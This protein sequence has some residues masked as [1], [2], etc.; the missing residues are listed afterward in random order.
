MDTAAHRGSLTGRGRTIAVLGCGI[1]IIY[2]PENK[3]LNVTE[4]LR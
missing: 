4:L 3:E 1:D 2:P